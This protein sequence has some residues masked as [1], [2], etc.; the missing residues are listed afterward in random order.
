M[1]KFLKIASVIWLLLPLAALS[2]TAS[3]Q[4]PVVVELFTSEGCSSCPPAEAMLIKLSHQRDTNIA[5]LVLLEEHVTYWNT[6]SFTDR[7]STSDLTDRQSAYVKDLHLETP[8][9]PQIVVDGKLQTSGNRPGTVQEYILDQAKVTKPATVTLQL[10]AP[11]RLQVTVSGPTDAKAQVLFAM[12]ED[13]LST[14][15]NGGE[16]KGRT[17]QHA[18]VVRSMESLGSLSNGHF[19]KTVKIPSKSDW[20]KSELHAVVLVQEK[21]SGAMLGAATVALTTPTSS[22]GAH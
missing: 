14:S 18:A 11:D 4:Q 22:S 10:A 17:L 16:N 3:A 2:D 15:V 8:Y 19:D 1:T 5:H 9:T 13:A 12:T 6:S 7:F 21:S 20:N